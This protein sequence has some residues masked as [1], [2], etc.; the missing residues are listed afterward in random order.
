[1]CHICLPLSRGSPL[2]PWDKSPF[3]FSLIFYLLYH[4]VL[5]HSNTDFCFFLSITLAGSFSA[6]H[7]SHSQKVVWEVLYMSCFYWLMNKEL[8]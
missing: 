7:F 3:P 6:V 5:A 2:S 4:G 1:M 8:L